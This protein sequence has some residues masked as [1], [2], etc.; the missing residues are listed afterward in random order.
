MKRPLLTL[1]GVV[2]LAAALFA[3]AFSAGQ[4]F[5]GARARST[6]D[7][8][9]LQQEF[10][11]SASEMARIEKLHAG[12]LPQ[13][14]ENCRKIAAKKAELAGALATAPLGDAAVAKLL[15]ELG[16]LRARCQAQ[17]LQHFA[18]VSQAMPAAQ[19]RRYLA[20]MRRVT[21]G[22]HEQVEATMSESPGHAHGSH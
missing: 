6:D 10:Q 19:G 12:Y 20:E 7:L 15:T 3:A 22:T 13:C 4:H 14:E 8:A 18:E 16:E 17:M 2:A 5:W 9:W 1:I 21:L 11:L